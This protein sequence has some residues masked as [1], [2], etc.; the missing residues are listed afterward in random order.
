[1]LPISKIKPVADLAT[2]LKSPASAFDLAFAL[3]VV[4]WKSIQAKLSFLKNLRFNDA[5]TLNSLDLIIR[6]SAT[7][8]EFGISGEVAAKICSKDFIFR[9]SFTVGTTIKFTAEMVGTWDNPFGLKN[10]YIKDLLLEITPSGFGVAGG[11]K[12]GDMKAEAAVLFDIVNPARNMVHFQLESFQLAKVLSVFDIN[13][14]SEIAR[15]LNEI[16]IQLMRA[17]L[18]PP[19]GIQMGEKYYE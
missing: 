12:L 6:P 15:I 7:A 5:V 18:V 19:G 13:L 4:N 10:S 11:I 16:N 14:P 8:P 1:M 17:D 2:M 3:S 9:A